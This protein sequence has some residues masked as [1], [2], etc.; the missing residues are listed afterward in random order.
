MLFTDAGWFGFGLVVGAFDCCGL[1]G[2]LLW[3]LCSSF[4]VL[5]G[6]VWVFVRWCLGLWGGRFALY[7]LLCVWVCW[8]VRLIVVLGCGV[9]C[10]VVLAWLF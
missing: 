9:F 4:V 6:V 1:A 10:V 2:V 3:W 7:V 5:F 8:L